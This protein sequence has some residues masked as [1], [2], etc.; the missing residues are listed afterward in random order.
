MISNL[1]N[2]LAR[3]DLKITH[4]RS[5]TWAPGIDLLGLIGC[6]MLDDLP[7]LSVLQVGAN[8]GR[9][10]DWMRQFV[11]RERTHSVL[12]E[13]LPGPFEKLEH[14]YAGCDRVRCINAA[15]APDAGEATIFYASTDDT[16]AL[17]FSQY[18][19][20]E[21]SVV[22]KHGRAIRWAGGS[23]KEMVVPAVAAGSLLELFE[24][25]GPHLIGIDTEGFDAI[26]VQLL[27]DAGASPL[28]FVYEHCHTRGDDDQRC[29][30]RLADAG[31][32]LARI[33]RDT[34]AVRADVWQSSVLA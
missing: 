15:L 6:R 23:I 28:V 7:S 19:S 14:L 11:L 13:P 3:H 25:N 4:N 34:V 5:D 20:F 8:D 21:R 27:L 24:G 18:A 10:G 26:A 17:H 9:D 32:L 1:K 30:L 2:L 31:Y 29:R 33:N 22:A 12:V 16:E